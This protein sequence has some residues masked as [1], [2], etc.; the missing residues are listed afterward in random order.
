MKLTIDHYDCHHSDISILTEYPLRNEYLFSYP[1]I[2]GQAWLHQ[3]GCDC[4]VSVQNSVFADWKWITFVNHVKTSRYWRELGGS[5]DEHIASLKHHLAIER[6][7]GSKCPHF[8]EF[9]KE[10]FPNLTTYGEHLHKEKHHLA[11]RFSVAEVKMERPNR[12][13]SKSPL[14]QDTHNPP[15]TAR[16][17]RSHSKSASQV[18]DNY[19]PQPTARSQDNR[20]YSCDSHYNQRN[21]ADWRRPRLP[22]R[23]NY[24][25]QWAQPQRGYNNDQWQCYTSFDHQRSPPM[26][27]SYPHTHPSSFNSQSYGS[28]WQHRSHEEEVRWN[29]PPPA[30]LLPT[31]PPHQILPPRQPAEQSSLITQQG[32]QG[33]VLSPTPAAG[34]GQKIKNLDLIINDVLEGGSGKIPA[35]EE[36]EEEEGPSEGDSPDPKTDD[37][38]CKRPLQKAKRS[39]AVDLDKFKKMK[40]PKLDNEDLG[41][42]INSPRTHKER[43]L[44]A[45]VIRAYHKNSRKRLLNA[46]SSSSNTEQQVDFNLSALPVNIQ[47]EIRFIMDNGMMAENPDVHEASSQEDEDFDLQDIFSRFVGDEAAPVVDMVNT[48]PVITIQPQEN[49]DFVPPYARPCNVVTPQIIAPDKTAQMASNKRPCDERTTSQKKMRSAVESSSNKEDAQL[50]PLDEL[51]AISL[52]EEQVVVSLQKKNESISSLEAV[53]AKKKE[54]LEKKKK[55]RAELIAEQDILMKKRLAILKGAV[56]KSASKTVEST[57]ETEESSGD[58]SGEESP[59]KDIESPAQDDLL[60]KKKKKTKVQEESLEVS[61]PVP[62][63]TKKPTSG[64]K[65]KNVSKIKDIDKSAKEP[66]RTRAISKKIE[67]SVKEKKKMAKVLKDAKKTKEAECEEGEDE[68]ECVKSVKGKKGLKAGRKKVAEVPKVTKK[69]LKNRAYEEIEE[70]VAVSDETSS[71]KSRPSSRCCSLLMNEL[72][73]CMIRCKT[74]I[75]LGCQSGQLLGS[76]CDEKEL[77]PNEKVDLSPHIYSLASP[78]KTPVTC[79]EAFAKTSTLY[80]VSASKEGIILVHNIPEGNLLYELKLLSPSTTVYCQG[81]DIFIGCQNGRVYPCTLNICLNTLVKHYEAGHTPVLAIASRKYNHQQWLCVVNHDSSSIAVIPCTSTNQNKT[82]YLETSCQSLRSIRVCSDI[83]ISV[84]DDSGK[85]FIHNLKHWLPLRLQSEKLVSIVD[86]SCSIRISSSFI[87]AKKRP[88][89]FILD[90]ERCELFYPTSKTRIPLTQPFSSISAFCNLNNGFLICS[91]SSEIFYS[92]GFS[93]GHN[94]N[95]IPCKI[96]GCN[97]LVKLHENDFFEHVHQHHPLNSGDNFV[98]CLWSGCKNNKIQ[99]NMVMNHWLS[100][101]KEEQL[102]RTAWKQ[103]A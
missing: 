74:S 98:A 22:P 37:A 66:R 13:I 21:D 84:A 16:P 20:Q 54:L 42:L 36:E 8:C 10:F 99:Q 39:S 94:F 61:T 18:Q 68:I 11:L 88:F 70:T 46:R 80:S 15:T 56:T 89:G 30:P 17:T 24:R 31:P 32:P 57:V 96:D 75:V 81:S 2:H 58:E 90:D 26:R 92:R 43:M 95:R 5:L 23:P 86:F 102:F 100:H 76:Y 85:L 6:S 64:I 12:S 53:I 93:K 82:K 69:S 48:A 38:P 103:L 1:C 41:R 50:K 59:P 34:K 71:T 44:I 62:K 101:F 72:V 45:K 3:Q 19:N 9:C 25:D 97:E 65:V 47:E 60:V 7:K 4:S 35:P 51:L 83:C 91:Q 78:H 55:A 29:A 33:K 27:Y 52:R 14:L 79:V 28:N 49:E 87:L 40:P 73:T 67:D 77:K 63:T